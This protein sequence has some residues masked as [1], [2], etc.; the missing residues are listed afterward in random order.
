[1]Y[2]TARCCLWLCM[3]GDPSTPNCGHVRMSSTVKGTSGSPET[4]PSSPPGLGHHRRRRLE[5]ARPMEAAGTFVWR[6]YMGYMY[7]DLT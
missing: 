2:I 7:G 4:I 1:M 5:K 3:S 6:L